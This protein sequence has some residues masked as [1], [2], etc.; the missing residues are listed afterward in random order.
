MVVVPDYKL[1]LSHLTDLSWEKGESPHLP[2]SQRLLVK[3]CTDYEDRRYYNFRNILWSHNIKAP[4]FNKKKFG[5]TETGDLPPVHTE[6]EEESR[7]LTIPL[8]IIY[9]SFVKTFYHFPDEHLE[10]TVH[11]SSI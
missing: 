8:I 3:I 6:M 7:L 1:S 11:M 10:E 4:L 2:T 9:F 5:S